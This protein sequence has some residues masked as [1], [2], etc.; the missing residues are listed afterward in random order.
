MIQEELIDVH[1]PG[2]QFEPLTKLLKFFTEG[3]SVLS[4]FALPDGS[5]DHIAAKYEL[6]KARW[7]KLSLGWN[8]HS[9]WRMR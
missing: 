1:V 4:S 7:A 3:D 2:L 8:N 6:S 5:V 9:R